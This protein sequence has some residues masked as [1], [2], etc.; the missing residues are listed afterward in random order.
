MPVVSLKI[1]QEAQ[2]DVIL[3]IDM[4]RTNDFSFLTTISRQVL[5]QTTEWVPNKTSKTYRS[6]LD[7]IFRLYNLPGFRTN[8]IHS[9]NEYRSLMQ[10]LESVYE[11]NTNPSKTQE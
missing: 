1:P 5:Y 9:D 2:Q 3:C 8:N 10:E 4:M 11:V 6:A 7:N